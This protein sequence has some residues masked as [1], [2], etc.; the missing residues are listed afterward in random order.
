[1]IY[2]RKLRTYR[3]IGTNLKIRLKMEYIALDCESNIK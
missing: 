1:M 3:I 2:N